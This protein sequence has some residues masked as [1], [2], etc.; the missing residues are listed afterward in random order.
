MRTTRTLAAAALGALLATAPAFSGTID[1]MKTDWALYDAA[2]RGTTP[3]QG[4][5][6]YCGARSYIA[7]RLAEEGVC[8][9]ESTGGW[10]K[11]SAKD[12]YRA[13]NPISDD[14]RASF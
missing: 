9:S 13:P 2:C 12:A 3:A 1:E 7:W 4:S 8:L 11:C 14:L 10:T 6:G 5:D